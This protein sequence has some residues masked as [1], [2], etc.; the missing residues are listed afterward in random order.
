MDTK[1]WFAIVD[2]FR[3]FPLTT[4]LD[5]LLQDYELLRAQLH[6]FPYF[7][8][9]HLDGHT[10]VAYNPTQIDKDNYNLVEYYQVEGISHIVSPITHSSPLVRIR[11]FMR[12]QYEPF[13]PS[14]SSETA[15]LLHPTR[16]S[17]PEPIA[18]A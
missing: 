13:V 11:C 18:E 5:V 2:D 17:H 8:A 9:S 4:E 7:I 16:Y 14:R 1:V 3:N 6:S 12:N 10:Y 15:S